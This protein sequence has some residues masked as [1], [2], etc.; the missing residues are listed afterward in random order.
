LLPGT[1]A[2]QKPAAVTAVEERAGR[3]SLSTKPNPLGAIRSRSKESAAILKHQATIL[4][5]HGVLNTIIENQK[6][7]LVR[8]NK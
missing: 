6:E 5:N 7:I 2:Q 1:V 3:T 4:K 8:L